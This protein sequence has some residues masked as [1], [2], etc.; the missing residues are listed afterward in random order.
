M[1]YLIGEVEREELSGLMERLIAFDYWE[2]IS[3]FLI[4]FD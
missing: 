1:E 3:L 2:C 4:Y